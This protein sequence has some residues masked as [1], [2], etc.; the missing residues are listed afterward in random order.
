MEHNKDLSEIEMVYTMDHDFT[1]IS[2]QR[3]EEFISM[4]AKG[5]E[6]YI[7]GDWYGA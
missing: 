5:L 3:N 1:C 7:I 6:S 2:K 4:Y